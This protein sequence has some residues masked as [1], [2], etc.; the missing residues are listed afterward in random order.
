MPV[1]FQKAATATTIVAWSSSSQD[2]AVA[3][4]LGG[5]LVGGGGREV[6][7]AKGVL[8]EVLS[9]Y[10]SDLTLG[11]LVKSL[12]GCKVRGSQVMSSH[13]SHSK[14]SHTSHPTLTLIP[15]LC[16]HDPRLI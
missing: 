12:E 10:P 13:T 1:L 3:G 16:P 15:T 4:G 14:S 6:L 9:R 8:V 5:G 2:Q 11:P 7:K